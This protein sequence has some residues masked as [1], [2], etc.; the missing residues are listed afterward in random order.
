MGLGQAFW[1]HGV[2]V[3]LVV[4]ER[5]LCHVWLGRI[6]LCRYARLYVHWCGRLSGVV[7]FGFLGYHV[8]PS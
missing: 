6:L 4:P 2:R 5:L 7:C 1:M 8:C 3:W